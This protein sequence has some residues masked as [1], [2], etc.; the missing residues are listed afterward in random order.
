MR[1]ARNSLALSHVRTSHL[2]YALQAFVSPT[3]GA[4]SWSDPWFLV[5]RALVSHS[6]VDPVRVL[7]TL[8]LQNDR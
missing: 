7:P 8:P 5:N 4:A 2:S 6:T 1:H 3:L